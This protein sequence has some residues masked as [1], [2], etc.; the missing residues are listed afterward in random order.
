MT[1]TAFSKTLLL[2]SGCIWWGEDD[3]SMKAVFYHREP[4]AW[5]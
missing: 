4:R 3:A 1:F 2:S 5:S